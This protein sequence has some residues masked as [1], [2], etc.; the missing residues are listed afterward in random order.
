M[1]SDPQ[2]RLDYVVSGLI[3]AGLSF[4]QRQ[5]GS[6]DPDLEQLLDGQRTAG[7]RPRERPEVSTKLLGPWRKA[8]AHFEPGGE[9]VVFLSPSPASRLT[10]S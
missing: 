1:P 5:S 9:L 7:L 6:N 2:A 10:S 3:R 4:A 8:N